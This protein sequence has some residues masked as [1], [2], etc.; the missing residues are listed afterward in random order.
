[1]KTPTKFA[2]T[3]LGIA[4]MAAL[5]WTLAGGVPRQPQQPQAS[6][7]RQRAL[8]RH[9]GRGR[10][11]VPPD[12]VRAYLEAIR[13]A[14]SPDERLRATI[15]LANFL[16]TAELGGW[17][18]N[19]WFDIR[20]GCD[21]DFFT[22]I[23]LQ[24][25]QTEDPAGYLAYGIGHQSPD[26]AAVLA[27]WAVRNP[28]E[29][30][31]YFKTHRNY[32]LETST[33]DFL[34]K[35]SPALALECLLAFT[36]SDENFRCNWNGEEV[37]RGLSAYDPGAFFKALDSLPE[38]WKAHARTAYTEEQL[39][40][41]FPD[42]IRRLWDQPGSWAIFNEA[43]AGDGERGWD[44]HS[45]GR[46][47]DEL[48]NLPQEWLQHLDRTVVIDE[49]NFEKARGIDWEAA[50]VPADVAAR[51]RGEILRFS[52]RGN[53]D[54]TLEL[55]AAGNVDANARTLVFDSLLFRFKSDSPEAEAFI[56]KLGPEENRE[57][58]RQYIAKQNPPLE[59][60]E[61]EETVT[62]SVEVGT[63]DPSPPAPVASQDWKTKM[64]Q[65]KGSSPDQIAEMASDFRALPD[66]QKTGAALGIIDARG[67]DPETQK[68]PLIGDAVLYLLNHP[69]AVANSSEYSGAAPLRLSSSYAVALGNDDPGAASAWVD[70]LPEGEPRLWA[71]KNL[72]ANWAQTIPMRCGGGSDPYHPRP[73]SRCRSISRSH[74]GE[75]RCHLFIRGAV[76]NGR[77]LPA[78]MKS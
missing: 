42:E 3:G 19:G 22:Q 16:P 17:I 31:D 36:A 58:A 49:S 6:V 43:V 63:P 32:D 55:L 60:E 15:H 56:A 78:L 30:C 18:E 20:E 50:G 47:L 68:S 75:N 66:D 34:A 7:A 67:F 69:E 33:L 38:R 21:F 46:L 4:V 65:S 48:P 76:T 10:H 9:P 37:L 23:V 24:R 12:E 57:A 70:S 25:W 35:I 14:G 28:Q 52:Q 13:R 62:S 26:N 41:S 74:G 73:G 45:A 53:P 77:H 71:A 5:G 1:M 39:K 72:A 54:V 11:Q 2:A 61:P 44:S 51:L 64:D 8:M 29:V 40:V 27:A 59:E